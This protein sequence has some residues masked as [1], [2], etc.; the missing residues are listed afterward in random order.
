MKAYGLIPSSGGRKASSVSGCNTAEFVMDNYKMS[1]AEYWTTNEKGKSE[2]RY[3]LHTREPERFEDTL[4]YD[5]A[6]PRC[7]NKLRLCGRPV[8]HYDHGLYRCPVCNR[9]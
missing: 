5:I 4:E 6:C 1:L 9:R 3:R 2:R 8:D 7:G